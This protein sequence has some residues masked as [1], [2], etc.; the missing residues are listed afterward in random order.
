MEGQWKVKQRQCR[1]IGEA[2]GRATAAAQAKASVF[3]RMAVGVQAKAVTLSHLPAD[4][5]EKIPIVLLCSTKLPAARPKIQR[6]SVSAAAAVD[7]EDTACR[8]VRE[9]GARHSAVSLVVCDRNTA[10]RQREWLEEERSRRSRRGM[11]SRRSRR[12]MSSSSRSSSRSRSRSRSR[13]SSSSRRSRR[14]SSRRSSSRRSSRRENF[15][16]STGET[17][18]QRQ[19]SA[20]LT[21]SLLREKWLDAATVGETLPIDI[22]PTAEQAAAEGGGAFCEAGALPEEEDE[23]DDGEEAEAEDEDEDEEEDEDVEARGW[24]PWELACHGA[25]SCSKDSPRGSQ[26]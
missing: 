4:Q 15:A 17:L 2:D 14:S 18:R 26:L 12:G 1:T 19:K 25:Y 16:I 22:Q 5:C 21:Y 13:S 6:V 9:G 24:L 8:S 10:L 20:L 3:G 23:E 11:R 7:R